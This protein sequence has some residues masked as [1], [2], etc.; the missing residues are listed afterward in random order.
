MPPAPTSEHCFVPG[1]HTPLQMP[2][3]QADDAQS[4]LVPQGLPTAQSD[5]HEPPQSTAVSVPFFTPSLHRAAAHLLLVHLPL[6]GKMQSEFVPHGLPTAQP[7]QLPPQSVSLS[8]PLRTMSLQAAGAHLPPVHL[9]LSGSLQSPF[10]LH[11]PLTAQ[12]PQLP[13]QSVSV[14][15]PF[16]APSP[17][18][19]ATQS[20]SLQR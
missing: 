1:E 17:Q 13:P 5:G 2:L 11:T 19:A 3:T 20:P 14:S 10:S 12:P 18:L 4:A 16:F 7:V 8:E 15:S 9:P 6:A